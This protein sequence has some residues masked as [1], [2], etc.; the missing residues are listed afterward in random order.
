MGREYFYLLAPSTIYIQVNFSK[1]FIHSFLF[2]FLK[3]LGLWARP[4][5]SRGCHVQVVWSK[6]LEAS[7][8]EKPGPMVLLGSDVRNATRRK[9]Q[10][11]HG[12][13]VF[14]SSVLW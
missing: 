1:V 7:I 14:Y 5:A 2:L 8:G 9:M 10:G 13:T 4:V 6:P 3:C 11:F 12:S